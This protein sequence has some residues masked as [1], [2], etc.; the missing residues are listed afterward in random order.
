MKHQIFLLT[1]YRNH[2]YEVVRQ[3]GASIDLDLL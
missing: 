1:D 3:R 2:F